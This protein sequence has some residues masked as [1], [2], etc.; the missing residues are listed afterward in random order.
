MSTD[1]DID[2][3]DGFV[4]VEQ[5]VLGL[6]RRTIPL[7][8]VVVGLV[9]LT[10]VVLPGIDRQARSEDLVQAGD[11]L[12]LASPDRLTI[13]PPPGW[14]LAEGIRRGE[15]D[16]VPLPNTSELSS[17]GVLLTVEAA[18]FGGTPEELLD[19]VSERNVLQDDLLDIG[20]V[21]E[22]AE[23]TL[24]NGTVGAVDV[25]TGLNRKGVVMAFVVDLGGGQTVGV[26]LTAIGE[27]DDLN[28]QLLEIAA[29]AESLTIQ[30]VAPEAP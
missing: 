29:M 1:T 9:L 25:Y 7:S 17:D 18:P 16:T 5:R 10:V 14:D 12:L 20:S 27:A 13:D 26:E 28:A 21:S 4:P 19:Q 15:V 2:Q 3:E 22:R 23:I 8:L 11:Q 30:P 24:D 6:D